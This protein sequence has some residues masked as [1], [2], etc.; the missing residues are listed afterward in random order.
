MVFAAWLSNDN[1][2]VLRSWGASRHHTRSLELSG[3][4]TFSDL[5]LFIK[6][7]DVFLTTLQ[8]NATARLPLYRVQCST[9]ADSL[10]EEYDPQPSIYK[11]ANILQSIGTRT[12]EVRKRP[13]R[14]NPKFERENAS[15]DET[16]AQPQKTFRQTAGLRDRS[17][18]EFRSSNQRRTAPRGNRFSS[19]KNSERAHPRRSVGNIGDTGL[20]KAAREDS[21][22]VDRHTISD[23]SYSDV[24]DTEENTLAR[25]PFVASDSKRPRRLASDTSIGSVSDHDTDRDISPFRP[26]RPASDI[27]YRSKDSAAPNT[28]DDSLPASSVLLLRFSSISNHTISKDKTQGEEAHN[29]ELLAAFGK[30]IQAHV[31]RETSNQS[32]DLALHQSPPSKTSTLDTG[33]GP[34]PTPLRPPRPI[35][36]QYIMHISGSPSFNSL[37]AVKTFAHQSNVEFISATLSPIRGIGFVYFPSAAG[38]TAAIERLNGR[39]FRGGRVN[40]RAVSP[41]PSPPPPRPGTIV[42]RNLNNAGGSGQ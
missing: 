37:D 26:G 39:E 18:T 14:G 7:S 23:R 41:P 12:A 6:C 15:E 31:F 32:V 40:C 38:I 25:K 29:S 11:N 1:L 21:R 8:E 19:L 24:S 10:D 35:D 3:D 33:N 30:K 34:F 4:Y 28:E 36:S 5:G 2:I 22:Q 9:M 27:P 16:E 42:H 17:R 20:R 13:G